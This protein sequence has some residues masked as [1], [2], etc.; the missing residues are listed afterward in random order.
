M[1]TK[2]YTDA[3]T[4]TLHLC[5]TLTG[6]IG[7]NVDWQLLGWIRTLVGDSIGCL[8]RVK[9]NGQLELALLSLSCA[10]TLEIK[11]LCQIIKSLKYTVDGPIY[12]LSQAASQR[13]AAIEA[14][15]IAEY[16]GPNP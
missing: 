4:C 14:V 9:C 12:D 5:S 15:K 3:C 1:L 11:M 7:C 16:E 2:L 8:Q 6:L 10:L 13:E